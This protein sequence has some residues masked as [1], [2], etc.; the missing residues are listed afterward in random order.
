LPLPVNVGRQSVDNQPDRDAVLLAEKH[1][2]CQ[3]LAANAKRLICRISLTGSFRAPTVNRLKNPLPFNWI[4]MRWFKPLSRA[5][6]RFALFIFEPHFK[7][8]AELVRLLFQ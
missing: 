3:G 1:V 2:E 5:G 6:R 4:L 8:L 7:F